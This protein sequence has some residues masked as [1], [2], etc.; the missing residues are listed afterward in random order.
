MA[1]TCRNL[2]I[3]P[4][5]LLLDVAGLTSAQWPTRPDHMS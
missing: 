4:N 3:Y 5:L 2:F 1:H